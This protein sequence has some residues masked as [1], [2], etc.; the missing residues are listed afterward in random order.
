MRQLMAI[1]AK[2]LAESF[3]NSE[4]DTGRP[5]WS[6]KVPTVKGT[7]SALSCA[8][9]LVSRISF[10]VWHSWI[11]SERTSYIKNCIARSHGNSMFNF[12]RN[13]HTVSSMIHI[14]FPPMISYDALSC[15]AK[16]L[17]KLLLFF[18]SATTNFFCHF[19]LV[20]NTIRWWI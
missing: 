14:L 16:S 8:L 2:D 17:L 13:R 9:F 12:F 11:L 10:S 1:P 3:L 19:S 20:P 5:M 15:P 6:S 7:E 18:N 4:G